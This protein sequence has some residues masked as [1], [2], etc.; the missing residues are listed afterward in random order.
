MVKD[1]KK[2]NVL[3][4]DPSS[5]F[6]GSSRCLRD[7]LPKLDKSRFRPVVAVLD[8]GPAIKTIRERGFEVISLTDKTGMKGPVFTPS[9]VSGY[10]NFSIYFFKR[11]LPT[12]LKLMRL[13]RAR[14]ID[15]VHINTPIITGLEAI[16]A[17]KLAG[18]PSICHL[19]ET[20]K[21]GRMERLMAGFVTKFICLTDHGKKLYLRYVKDSKLVR[22]YNGVSVDEKISKNDVSDIRSQLG[23]EGHFKLV[24][25]VGRI[26][27]GKGHDIFL[28]AARIVLDK[29]PHTKFVIVGDSLVESEERLKNDLVELC[30]ET[31]ID[32]NVIF[33]GWREDAS[34][35]ISAMDVLIQ[36]STTFPEGF[37]LTCIEAMALGVPLVVTDIPGSSEIVVDGE[38]GYV[39]PPGDP[40]AMAK[41]MMNILEDKSLADKISRRE[42]E[43]VNDLF[44]LGKIVNQI[45]E[46]YSSVAPIS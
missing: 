39:V 2:V 36:A 33:T 20:R 17:A 1:I 45:E 18:I 30:R 34:K 21:W 12:A 15:V 27:G 41:G 8:D 3:Y 24:G 35:I 46:V 23:V 28:K 11:V 14:K 13:I 9:M 19:H 5:G 43:R 4:Y 44:E 29:H 37:G 10:W 42:R 6:G 25:I 31:G 22:I 40:D 16:Y 26:T 38:T 7:W 32:K